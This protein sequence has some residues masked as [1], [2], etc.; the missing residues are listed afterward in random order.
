MVLLPAG[1][2]GGIVLVAGLPKLCWT[3]CSIS[4][5]E[6][7]TE[8]STSQADAVAMQQGFYLPMYP[9]VGVAGLHASHFCPDMQID[10]VFKGGQVLSARLPLQMVIS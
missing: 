5:K 7:V 1:Q 6:L 3:T 8:V 9:S 4:L 10:A 2:H